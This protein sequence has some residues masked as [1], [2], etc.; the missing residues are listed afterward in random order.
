MAIIDTLAMLNIAVDDV[1][2]AKEFYGSKLGLTVTDDT[3]H[4]GQRWVSM[5]F[6]EGGTSIILSNVHENMKPG[7][8]KLYL[9]CSDIASLRNEL[10]AKGIAPS[11]EGDDWGKWDSP[12]GKGQQWF[13]L[14]DPDGNQVLV[15]PSS[16]HHKQT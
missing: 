3:D 15:I 13:E 5:A 14:T 2:K 10:G 1:D 9:A 8:M 16:Y 7:T 4:G 11:H 6:P 12:D